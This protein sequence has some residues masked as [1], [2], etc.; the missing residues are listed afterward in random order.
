MPQPLALVSLLLLASLASLTAAADAGVD[1][2]CPSDQCRTLARTLEAQQE[3]LNAVEQALR[4]LLEAA[5]PG[6]D[7]TTTTTVSPSPPD[8]AALA[9]VEGDAAGVK[10]AVFSPSDFMQRRCNL[11]RDCL[12]LNFAKKRHLG[13][14]PV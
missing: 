14:R 12:R 3:R 11:Q 1:N 5:S 10:G 8:S 9:S 6:N 2:F 7:A 13:W 4:R